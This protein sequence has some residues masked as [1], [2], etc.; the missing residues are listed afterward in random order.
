M[1]GSIAL[2]ASDRKTLLQVYRSASG[3]ASRR[4]HVVL[5]AADGWSVRDL[6]RATFASFDFIT[7][8]LRHYRRHGV[9]GIL[10]DES[11]RP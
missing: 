8:T 10:E 2:S 5:L 6:R 1:D 11:P 9:E 4:A 3:L 7:Q